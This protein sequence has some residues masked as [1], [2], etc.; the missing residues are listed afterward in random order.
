M[1]RRFIAAGA[2]AALLMA[3]AVQPVAG[4]PAA[5]LPAAGQGGSK[6]HEAQIAAAEEA[7]NEPALRGHI[8]FL[9]D[10]LLEG[11]G[12]GSRGDKLTQLYLATQFQSLGLKPAAPDG[13]WIQPVPLVGVTTQVPQTLNFQQGGKSL[14]LKRHGDY[15]I[16]SGRP[17]KQVSVKDAEIVFVGYGIQAP[18]YQWDDF[19]GADLKGK[20]LLVMNNDPADDPELFAGKRRLYYGRWDYKYASAARQGAAGAIIIHTTASAGYPFQVVQTSWSGEEFELKETGGER[21]D[22][23]GWFTEDASRKLVSLAGQDLDKLRAAAERRDFKP[24]PLGVKLSLELTCEVRQQETGNVLALLPG[25]DPAKAQET[26]VF[27]AHHDHLGLAAERN[28]QGDNIYNGAVDNAA[29]TAALL[30]IARACAVL[31]KRPAR[32]ILFAAVGAEEQGLLGSEYLAEHSPIPAGR[33]AA[34]INIDG[35]NIIGPT[36]DVNVIGLGK[37][38]LDELVGGI[39]RW[40]SRVVTPD[41]FPD[42]GYYYRS[43]QFSLAKI[44]VPGVYLHSG[45]NVVGKPEGWGKKQLEEWTETKYHQPSDEYDANWDLRGAIEDVRLLCYV[46]LL[47]AERPE[48]PRW[49]AG[50][51]FEAARKAALEAVK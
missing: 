10:D 16:T 33:L 11:R 44:G 29:G 28:A 4:Q 48:M 34:V 2:A 17:Q 25:S 6:P 1:D 18:E 51:E 49:N 42:R 14:E 7:I 3:A 12:P 26:V 21:L 5:G 41:E 22:M 36:K 30:T 13:G 45:V 15:V 32:S 43:D 40:Q 19:K 20:I 46:G 9:A 39:A 23:R 50:D 27:M 35:V 24:V 37:S 8:R 31:E 47:A 38:N